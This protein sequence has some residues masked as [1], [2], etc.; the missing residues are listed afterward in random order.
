MKR[1][2]CHNLSTPKH[3]SEPKIHSTVF[4]CLSSFIN[5]IFKMV[6]E[7]FDRI[8][9]SINEIG[10]YTIIAITQ[11]IDITGF[12][13]ILFHDLYSVLFLYSDS[14]KYW[15]CFDFG[16]WLTIILVF[17]AVFYVV[18]AFID[19]EYF[20]T[21]FLISYFMS[22]CVL[23]TVIAKSSM[24]LLGFTDTFGSVFLFNLLFLLIRKRGRKFK[25][26]KSTFRRIFLKSAKAG[27]V[28]V[29]LISCF[30]FCSLT[31]TKLKRNIAEKDAIQNVKISKCY[32]TEN[33]AIFEKFNAENWKAMSIPE[34]EVAGI[35]L[36]QCSLIY[37]LGY[38]DDSLRFVIREDY[39]PL[40]GG[41][42]SKRYNEIVADYK[43]IENRDYI[44]SLI[45]HESYHY[46]QHCVL[47]GKSDLHMLISEKSILKYK[48][49][50]AEYT[51]IN[52]DFD[53]YYSQ[54]AEIDARRYAEIVQPVYIEYIDNIGVKYD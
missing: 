39:S 49:E 15:F 21:N 45:C 19:I 34:K 51:D 36:I 54:Q 41:F 28:F 1:G 8:V 6:I 2:T 50:F 52:Q 29:L 23:S 16:H 3:I 11:A 35:Q 12:S 48:K 14:V 31:L 38:K 18:I 13:L 44:I 20:C 46:F 47:Q 7:F 24:L 9:Q 10:W 5:Y 26:I 40:A 53:C 4:L 33:R 32:I 30:Y 27:V 17:V 22:I 25:N 42:Y 37:L 43:Y